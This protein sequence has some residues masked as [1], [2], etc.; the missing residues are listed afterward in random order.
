VSKLVSWLKGL[1]ITEWMKSRIKIS[2]KNV[3]R[4]NALQK[5]IWDKWGKSKRLERLANWIN[6]KTDNRFELTPEVLLAIP[7]LM[8]Y[9]RMMIVSFYLLGWMIGAGR[10]FYLFVYLGL[11]FLDIFDGAIAR[12]TGTTSTFGAYIDPYSDKICHTSAAIAAAGLGLIP[13][14]V[15]VILTVKEIILVRLSSH[16]GK[17]G[18]GSKWFGKLGTGVEVA[19]LSASFAFPLWLPVGVFYSLGVLHWL[20]LASYLIPE[21]IHRKRERA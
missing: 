17:E 8:C 10:L 3:K 16:Y 21:Y 13:W 1:N 6:Q 14:L 9:F 19:L 4:L 18:G 7:S 15:V 5:K 11:M 20:I 2:E 12:Q